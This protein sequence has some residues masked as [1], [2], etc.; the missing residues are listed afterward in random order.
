MISSNNLKG[1]VESRRDTF[2]EMPGIKFRVFF[3]ESFMVTII[4]RKTAVSVE[5]IMEDDIEN[6][7]TSDLIGIGKTRKH[8]FQMLRSKLQEEQNEA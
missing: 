5:L 2:K 4:S 6:Q 1:W 3:F 7:V 8:A